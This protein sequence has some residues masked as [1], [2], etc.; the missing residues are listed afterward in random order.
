MTKRRLDLSKRY[1]QPSLNQMFA[2]DLGGDFTIDGD[3]DAK[4]MLTSGCM[5]LPR[6][7]VYLWNA[8]APF[9]RQAGAH[10]IQVTLPGAPRGSRIHIP[11]EPGRMVIFGGY[12]RN[13][14]TWVLWDAELFLGPAGL[15]YS[16][17]FQVPVEGLTAASVDGFAVSM[18]LVRETTIGPTETT[19][20][21]CRRSHLVQGLQTRF[22]LSIDRHLNQTGE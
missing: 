6:L 12:A 21:T 7:Q 22:R 3:V 20:V 5:G 11:Q 19:I 1:V 4:P 18:K 17:N 8:T 10:K 9:E 13:F 15:S 16:R 2:K 14:G